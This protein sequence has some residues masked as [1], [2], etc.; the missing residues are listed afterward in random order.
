MAIAQLEVDRNKTSFPPVNWFRAMQTL[1]RSR[2]VGCNAV[3]AQRTRLDSGPSVLPRRVSPV[4]ER[5]GRRQRSQCAVCH[6]RS[7]CKPWAWPNF[8]V[9]NARLALPHWGRFASRPLDLTKVI[10]Q[11]VSQVLLRYS[12]KS[13]KRHTTTLRPDA[14]VEVGF[15]RERSDPARTRTRAS[16]AIVCCK[17][18][19]VFLKNSS[20][21]T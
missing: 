6:R 16:R 4:G 13:G 21:S 11:Q 7:N 5:A 2:W 18:T 9:A 20:S 14:I 1:F 10:V 8:S 17:S 15:G 19:F 3:S 12:D